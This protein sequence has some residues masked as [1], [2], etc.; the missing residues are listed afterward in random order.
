MYTKIQGPANSAERAAYDYLQGEI[1]AGRLAGGAPIRQEEI[2][3]HLS[4]SRVPVR[5]ALKH[6]AAE[7]LVTVESNRRAVV[8]QL[9]ESDLRELFEMRTVLEGL[10]V[11]HAVSQLS[12]AELDHLEWLAK[13][14]DQTD[15]AG[16][17]WVPIHNEFHRLLSSRSGMPRLV[18]EI[19]LLRQSVEPYARM[20]IAVQGAAAMKTND[21]LTL[22]KKLRDRNP[23]RAERAMRDHVMEASR[24]IM[25][26]I[27]ATQSGRASQPATPARRKR[28]GN[29]EV[30]ASTRR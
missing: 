18:R 26:A 13:R 7:G 25:T 14:M 2:A 22:V 20:V 3:E 10:A 12:D 6:L 29:A 17:Q 24:D 8:T 1:L 4:V 23:E 28:P 15:T 9:R 11:R 21:H 5:D 30:A 16:D 19:A 27:R